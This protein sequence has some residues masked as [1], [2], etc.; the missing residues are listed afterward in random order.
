MNYG[1]NSGLTKAD[2]ND[3]KTL[4]DLTWSRQ[5]TEIDGAQIRFVKPYHETIEQMSVFFEVS[6]G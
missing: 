2:K 1:E 5:L 6:I 4:Y 3:L